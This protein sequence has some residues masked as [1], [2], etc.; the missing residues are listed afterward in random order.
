MT[1]R[2]FIGQ[3]IGTVAAAG[4]L[5]TPLIARS[6]RLDTPNRL[7]KLQRQV[8][9]LGFNEEYIKKNYKGAMNVISNGISE[10]IKMPPII[11][12]KKDID[13]LKIF[14]KYGTLYVTHEIQVRGF[15]LLDESNRLV[16]SHTIAGQNLFPDDTF[17]LDQTIHM[18][19]D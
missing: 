10:I 8:R 2:T 12:V 9:S 3:T 15:Y 19:Y 14:I 5:D 4:L 17:N 1:R 7:T 16:A 13:E 6:I 11:L 18:K